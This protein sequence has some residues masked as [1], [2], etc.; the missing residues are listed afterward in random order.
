MLL[1]FPDSLSGR[2]LALIGSLS[3][4]LHLCHK[5]T[6]FLGVFLHFITGDDNLGCSVEKDCAF[7]DINDLGEEILAWVEKNGLGKPTGRSQRSGFV[8]YPEY[9][10]DAGRLREL[11]DYGYQEYSRIFEQANRVQHPRKKDSQER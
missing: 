3:F 11:D 4:S 2:F 8:V 6:F 5:T 1:S 7:V 9:R 10:F